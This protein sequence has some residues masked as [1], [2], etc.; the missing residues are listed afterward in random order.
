MAAL[1][2]LKLSNAKRTVAGTPEGRLRERLNDAIRL[3]IEAAEALVKG[4]SFSRHAERWT[5][6][7]QTGEKELKRVPIRFTQWWWKNEAGFYFLGI[8][9][10]N[11]FLEIKPKKTSIEVGDLSQLV[12]ALNT[13][14]TASEAGELDDALLKAADLRKTQFTGRKTGLPAAKAS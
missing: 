3:Q 8:R 11:R 10:G 5:T 13:L 4:Q 6:N 12:P 9:Y 7:A 2:T 14:L 1:D